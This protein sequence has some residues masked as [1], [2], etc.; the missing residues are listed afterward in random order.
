MTEYIVVRDYGYEG[1]GLQYVDGDQELYKAL[2]NTYSDVEFV[3]NSEYCIDTEEFKAR[4]ACIVKHTRASILAKLT[5][6]EIA[7]LG[8]TE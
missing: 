8:L 6:D 3:V 4:H 7:F 2:Q 1:Y 5:E